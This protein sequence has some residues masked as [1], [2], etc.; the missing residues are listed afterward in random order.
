MRKFK[1]KIRDLKYD[2]IEAKD[3]ELKWYGKFM[4]LQRSNTKKGSILHMSNYKLNGNIDLESSLITIIEANEHLEEETKKI[5]DENNSLKE[6]Y[7]T[8]KVELAE[9]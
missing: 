4:N 2:L 8:M 6:R 3:R 1:T 5:M 7:H 9:S